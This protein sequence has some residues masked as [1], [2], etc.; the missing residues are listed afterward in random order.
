MQKFLTPQARNYVFPGPKGS[1]PKPFQ[2]HETLEFVHLKEASAMLKAG[3]RAQRP[4]MVDTDSED[5]RMLGSMF[6]ED[7]ADTL[8]GQCTDT[9]S[10]LEEASLVDEDSADEAT[11]DQ[12]EDDVA[13][14]HD[15]DQQAGVSD[16][17][18]VVLGATR[19]KHTT[20]KSKKVEFVALV[21]DDVDGNNW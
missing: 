1:G 6:G 5:S 11:H 20:R 10:Q 18:H 8:S 4:Q 9:D 21:K 17:T 14:G 13:E 19:G 15:D 2:E 12:M 3:R 7:A 16:T